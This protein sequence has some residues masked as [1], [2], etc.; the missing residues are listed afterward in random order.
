MKP[1]TLVAFTLLYALVAFLAVGVA[2]LTVGDCIQGQAGIAR[3]NHLAM[4]R[5]HAGFLIA[6][7]LYP[8]ALVWLLWRKR[9]R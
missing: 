4:E 8:L 5:R 9:R 6:I 1:R 7:G 2:M 3:C